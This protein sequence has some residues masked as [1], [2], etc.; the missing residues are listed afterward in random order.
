MKQTNLYLFLI[1][2]FFL[3][4]F[5]RFWQL[6]NIPMSLN[7]DEA[8]WGYNAYTLGVDGKDEFGSFLPYKFIESY[9]DYKPPVYAY[10]SVLPV[11]LFGLNEFS[12]RFASA[13]FGSFSV[14]I[15]FFLVRR[16]FYTSDKKEY[17][18]LLSALFLGISPWNI[19]LSRAAFEANVAT[20]FVLTG[21]WLFL[22][23]IQEKKWYLPFSALMFALSF[24]TFNSPRIVVPFLGLALVL[25][26]YKKLLPRKREVMIAGLVGIV[27][28]APL[29]GFLLSPQA[30]LRYQE[31]NIFS[32]VS[33][34]KGINQEIQNDNNAVWSKILHN[35]R[36]IYALTYTKHYFDNL[37]PAFLF[38]SGDENHKFSTKDVGEMYF[39]DALFLLVGVFF[40]F[41]KKEGY[42]WVIPIWFLVGLI[43]ASTARETPHALRTEITLPTLQI[44][45]AYGFITLVSFLKTIEKRKKVLVL[46]LMSLLLF[47]NFL[48]YVHGYYFHYGRESAGEWNYGYKDSIAYVKKVENQYDEIR[49]TRKLGRPYAYYAFYMKTDPAFFRKTA[50]VARD[51]FG[52]VE[53][54]GFGKYQFADDLNGIPNDKNAKKI[55]YINIPEAVPENARI[56]ETFQYP[57][58]YHRLT[59]YTL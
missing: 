28:L 51:V 12:T 44:L 53:V 23:G 4:I 37:N 50:I 20:F 8:A 33:I 1:P 55:L 5:L 39:I 47:G 40:L 38:I 27:L 52:F 18:A 29:V 31:V 2:I 57:D 14:L 43:P 10:L 35:R 46:S 36:F 32:D 49:I 11:K 13:F 7:W 56:L 16:I 54:K 41:R 17:Y 48:Y 6:G 25:G 42:W 19:N 22:A 15:V 9:G 30:K 34:V 59:A 58:G 26:T 3:A 45:S 21:V 24:Y